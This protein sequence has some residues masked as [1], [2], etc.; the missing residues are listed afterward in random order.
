MNHCTGGARTTV[1][2]TIYDPAGKIPIYN[3]S[4]Y[5]PNAPLADIA[6]GPSCDPCDPATGSSLLSGSPIAITKT[7]TAGRF[8]L[9][10]VGGDVPAGDG[11]PL[12]IQVGKWR[13][14]VT[15]GAVAGCQ[16]NLLEDTDHNLRLPR[17]KGE[18]HIPKMALTTGSLDALECLLRKIGID[19]LEF[20]PET[21][22][23]RVNFYAGGG[24]TSVYDARLNG[25]APIT[26]VHPWWDSL[27]NLKKYDII[28]HSC[29]GGQGDYRNGPPTSAKSMQARQALQDFA[30]MGGRVFAS[31]WHSYWFQSGPPAFQRIATWTI[32]NGLPNPNTAFIDAARTPL[33][34]WMVNVMGSPA[35]M[36]GRVVLAQ[37]ASNTTVGAAAGGTISERWIY[38]NRNDQPPVY[39][40]ANTPVPA[41]PT[42][43]GGTC[44]KVVVSD[45]HVSA[46]AGTNS[47]QPNRPYPTGCITTDLSPQEKVLEYMLFDIASC[48]APIVP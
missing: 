25:G 42:D 14:Q 39:L 27:D 33:T 40:A 22:D 6:D 16:D 35:N 13:R 19:E 18:G 44:G 20:T 47:D 21:A 8:T 10:M 23:G 43:P 48:V 45:I 30:D 4:V 26:P 7:D 31:H 2:G 32:A 36:P 3:V 28:L 38:G 5:V 29:E 24:G 9:G 17:N 34:Q 11:V 46:G 1:S 41:T 15:L 37:N 12:V